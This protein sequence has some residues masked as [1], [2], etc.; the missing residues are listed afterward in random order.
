MQLSARTRKRKKIRAKI[1]G[2]ALKPRLS[3]FKSNTA[4]YAQIID[5]DKAIT[6]VSASGSDAKKVGE[7]IA[8]N[9]LGK[10][11]TNVVFD[12]GGY[13]YTGKIQILAES[14]RKGGLNF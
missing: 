5:D 4:I 8:K 11:I 13:V 1:F 9:A 14:A 6:L 3:I 12:R 2:T 7:T 10:K